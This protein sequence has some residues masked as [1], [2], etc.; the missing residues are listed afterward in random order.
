MKPQFTGHPP[1]VRARTSAWVLDG[2]LLAILLTRREV[3]N[4]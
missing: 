1:T 2:A 4:V 3:R